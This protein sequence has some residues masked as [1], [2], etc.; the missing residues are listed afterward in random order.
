LKPLD[1]NRQ[2]KPASPLDCMV[3]SR[4]R[5]LFTDLVF[6]ITSYYYDLILIFNI[7]LQ[8]LATLP[9]V[10]NSVFKSGFLIFLLLFGD[11]ASAGIFTKYHK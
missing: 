5:L 9:K 6:L 8:L 11:F 7:H 3:K 4:F 2:E 1:F 10:V